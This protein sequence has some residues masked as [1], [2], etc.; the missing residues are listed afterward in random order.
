M[1]PRPSLPP[2][3][4]IAP[5]AAAAAG[6]LLLPKRAKA[7]GDILQNGL[8][9]YVVHNAKPK[10]E[11]RLRLIVKAGSANEE[12]D[13]RG[14][15]HLV[16]HL[17]FAGTENFQ[18]ESILAS[19]Q[20]AGLTLGADCNATTS[21][22]CT[23]Y[24]TIA[25]TGADA[26]LDRALA[27]LADFAVRAFPAGGAV[28]DARIDKERS[29]VL[30]EMRQSLSADSRA[31]AAMWDAWFAGEP[32]ERRLPIGTRECVLSCPADRIRRWYRRWYVPERMAVVV[33]GDLATQAKRDSV[34]AR[35]RTH[36]SG[37]RPNHIHYC[38]CH[39]QHS[40]VVDDDDDDDD[41]RSIVRDAVARP[42]R[43]MLSQGRELDPTASSAAS[44][45]RFFALV[46]RDGEDTM[47]TASLFFAY[48]WRC[49]RR[50][51]TRLEVD[52][53]MLS[54]I[55]VLLLQS[56]LSSA[57]AATGGGQVEVVV[58]MPGSSA[59]DD[60]SG[61]SG[62]GAPPTLC[63][64]LSGFDSI[65]ITAV[66]ASSTAVD[67]IAA[68]ATLV[69][70]EL[71][72]VRERGFNA[73]E[74]RQMAAMLLKMYSV[75]AAGSEQAIDAFAESSSKQQLGMLS[76]QF[77]HALP[78]AFGRFADDN[79]AAMESARR[80]ASPR[81]GGHADMRR[82]TRNALSAEHGFVACMQVGGGNQGP[83]VPA[84]T[85]E[86]LIRWWQQVQALDIS[87]LV[88]T[89]RKA[90]V[91]AGFDEGAFGIDLDASLSNHPCG[92]PRGSFADCAVLVCEGANGSVEVTMS[93]GL[94][95]T[96]RPSQMQQGTFLL[97]AVCLVGA[98]DIL[99]AG[100]TLSGDALPLA[101]SHLHAA[102]SRAVDEEAALAAIINVSRKELNSV[103][104]AR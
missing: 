3:T 16:E 20:A 67:A 6:S 37:L 83:G 89:H 45:P 80:L 94:D 74:V 28:T 84:V 69:M 21:F 22:Q 78:A 77:R 59:D 39:G 72:L 63:G 26:E 31:F 103:V 48:R 9:F 49:P 56:R 75:S 97:E 101:L 71:R 88:E 90:M 23:W 5:S 35:I 68:T 81:G 47:T 65:E 76:E 87:S 85:E 13:E 62:G 86:D 51:G 96:L 38:D 29:I 40:V 64:E 46:E 34:E 50:L 10:G 73:S 15:A 82:Y 60:G 42:L 92:Q 14:I 12:E 104:H 70:R 54:F 32:Y 61:G 25:R 41:D 95:M 8:T 100:G 18:E 17:V 43:R 33:C 1:Q 91:A 7:Q 53:A 98:L 66:H 44:L 99:E 55:T 2:A 11:V 36:F 19:L 58:H 4:S 52:E 30:E 79:D 27:L 93:N 102:G 24:D 57:A